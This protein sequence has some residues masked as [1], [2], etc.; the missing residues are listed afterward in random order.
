E[1]K[2]GRGRGVESRVA[3]LNTRSKAPL[4]ALRCWWD[5]GP[6]L[7]RRRSRSRHR[8]LRTLTWSESRLGAER[9]ASALRTACNHATLVRA[10]KCLPCDGDDALAEL[11][12]PVLVKEVVP[13]GSLGGLGKIPPTAPRQQIVEDPGEIGE[14]PSM[15]GIGLSGH[16]ERRP[17]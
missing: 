12:V 16:V 11:G 9:P 8:R 6:E 2:R 10:P 14:V 1:K 13:I 17:G 5:L 15:R 7:G 4:E 3:R